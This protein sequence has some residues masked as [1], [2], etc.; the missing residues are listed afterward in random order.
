MSLNRRLLKTTARW[1]TIARRCV[2]RDSCWASPQGAF[3]L[4][5]ACIRL[6]AV[7][8]TNA[9]ATRFAQAVRGVWLALVTASLANAGH[10]DMPRAPADFFVATD[11]DDTWTGRLASPNEGRSDGPFATLA[12]ARDAIRKLKESGPLPVGGISVEVGGG[13]YEIDAVIDFGRLD[14]GTPDSPIEYRARPGEL[15]RFIGGRLV[16]GWRAVEDSKVLAQLAPE[17]TK[18]VLQVDLTS[19]GISDFGE[20]KAG[21]RWSYSEPG[22][23]L[24]FQSRPMVL[25]RWPNQG[26]VKIPEVLG[27][28]PI[29]GDIRNGC[30]EGVFRY[31][32]SRPARWAGATDVMLH[33]FWARDWADQRLKV[34]SIDTQAKIISVEPAPRHEFGFKSGHWYYAYN[35][36]SELDSPG[37]WYLDRQSRILYF[38]PPA[39]IADGDVVVSEIQTI[40]RFQDAA[41][42]TIRGMTLEACRG[43]AVQVTGGR[44]VRLVGCTIRNTGG[45][46]ALMKTHSSGLIGCDVANTGAGGFWL[47]GGDRRSLTPGNLVV[48]N[49]HVSRV[50]RW[51]PIM[52]PGVRLDG[53]GNRMSHSLIHDAPHAAVIWAGNEHLFEYNEFHS[54]VQASNDAG[55]MYSGFDPAARGTVIRHNYFH[56]VY[57]FEG[58]GCI[59]VYLDDCFCSATIFGNIIQSVPYAVFIGGGHDNVVEN[60]IFLDCHP[61]VHVDARMMTTHASKAPLMKQRLEELPYREEPWRSRYP[62]LLTYLKGNYAQPRNNLIARN[63]SWGSLWSDIA[64]DAKPGV[65]LVDNLVDQ[66]PQ[67]LKNASSPFELQRDSPA[68][69]LG[70][71]RIPTEE[72]GLYDSP[73]RAS[74]PIVH[75]VQSPPPRAVD[76]WPLRAK[77]ALKQTLMSKRVVW[78]LALLSL[79]AWGAAYR[80]AS[81]PSH[82]L[83]AVACAGVRMALGFAAIVLLSL[84]LSF[85]ISLPRRRIVWL[86]AAAVAAAVEVVARARKPRHR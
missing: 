22:L 77:R 48:D 35:L 12:R 18:R 7:A 68:W 83:L 53:V 36:L 14:G 80:F 28:T 86:A 10:S 85:D 34:Q 76:A 52:N 71:K 75:E 8:Q 51:N 66:N 65:R 41:Y 5:S 29:D 4:A 59:G 64:A 42:V 44:D 62:E 17:A 72:F 84:A 74:W 67:F 3:R 50:G 37:E 39:A 54:V 70:F 23:E 33:G 47:E 2:R 38:W 56:H 1:I 81:K 19:I 6:P 46:A 31:E 11:G 55:I 43:T 69:R 49:C 60:N 45:W 82:G 21:P 58:R 61:A 78:P 32:G 15:V 16:R 25:S 63:I 57:G 73:D 9:A 27:K 30:Q 26:F 24:F 13:A 40:L 20:M 79:V